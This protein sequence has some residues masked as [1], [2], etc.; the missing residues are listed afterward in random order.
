MH[1]QALEQEINVLPVRLSVGCLYQ[2]FPVSLS[3]LIPHL[4][5]VLNPLCGGR[6]L[7]NPGVRGADSC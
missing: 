5:P 2:N 3:E 1:L 6:V 4:S 7:V